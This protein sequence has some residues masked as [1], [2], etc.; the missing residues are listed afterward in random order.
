MAG[1]LSGIFHAPLT[2][3]FIIAEIT[4]GYE[5]II[6]LMIVS[7]LSYAV[8]QYFM[9]LSIDFT[10]LSKKEKIL[11]TNTDSY[12]LSNISLSDLVETDFM[13]LVDTDTLRILV[14]KVAVSRRNI[15]PILDINGVLKGLITIDDVREIMFKQE[16][17]DKLSMAQL[18]RLP[19]YVISEFD[20]ISSA[21]KQF[22][23]SHLWNIPV[24]ANGRYKG[25]ISKSSILEKYREV[26]IQTSLE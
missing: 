21:M 2:G 19:A 14:D 9:P 15:F 4:G 6:P 17:Y 20:D 3:I 7:A 12:L 18:M 23:E 22:D 10:K 13:E 25:F 11:R 16:L 8:S 5:L 24:V 26:L 1:L